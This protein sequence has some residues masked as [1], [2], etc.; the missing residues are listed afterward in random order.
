MSEG[1]S[2]Y[3][4]IL[5]YPN[6]KHASINVVLAYASDVVSNETLITVA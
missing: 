2:A 5:A 3:D 1:A 6:L 4:L